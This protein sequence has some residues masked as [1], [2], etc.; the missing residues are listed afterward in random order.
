[1]KKAEQK[2][3]AVGR[4][5]EWFENVRFGMFIHWGLYSLLGRGEWVMNREMIPV[6]EYA[7][8]ADA[9]SAKRF[10]PSKWAELALNA[11]MKYAVLTAKHHEGFCLWDSHICDFNA[12]RSAARRDLVGEYVEAFRKAGLKVGLYYSLGDWRNPD[13]ALGWKGDLA[14]KTR[15]MEYTHALVGELMSQYGKID[16]LWYDLPQ[17]YSA[18]EW[19]SVELNSLVRR[20]QPHIVINNRAMT[21]EDFGTPENH[22]SAAPKG[23]MWEA[24]MTLNDH[25]GYCPCDKNYKSPRT[26]IMNLL[27]TAKDGGN[28]LLN[29]GPDGNG[30][31]PAEPTEILLRVGEWLKTHSECV[32]SSERHVTTW[33]HW[34]PTTAKGRNLYLHLANYSGEEVVV[35]CL[36]NEVKRATLLSTEMP[37]KVRKDGS[38]HIISGL[39]AK[40]PAGIL[41]VVKLELDSKPVQDFTPFINDADI[42]PEF[43]K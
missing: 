16:I 41:S 31:I 2:A 40:E 14:A 30:E 1:M 10:N 27:Q 32:Y 34:G 42:F 17:C 23:R 20:L 25:W 39:P 43:P 18:A 15:F 28:L 6:G 24:C 5:M 19:R 38:R 37:L 3:A 8:L 12:T 33:N 26:V 21:T 36:K 11:G 9:F 22:V 29:V 13:W 7:N 4:R 35:A